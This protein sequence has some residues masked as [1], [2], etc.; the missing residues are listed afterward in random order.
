MLSAWN[1]MAALRDMPRRRWGPISGPIGVTQALSRR[2]V[3]LDATCSIRITD[4][5][6]CTRAADPSPLSTPGACI[7]G[8]RYAEDRVVAQAPR[9]VLPMLPIGVAAATGNT[10]PR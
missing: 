3:G 7:V 1:P 2:A 4:T 9:T 8:D 10:G 5:S 6:S